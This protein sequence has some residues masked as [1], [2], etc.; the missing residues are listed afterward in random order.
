MNG[1]PVKS[2]RKTGADVLEKHL[3]EKSGRKSNNKDV[4]QGF[5]RRSGCSQSPI[6][7]E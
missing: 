7:L 5:N 2:K 1:A 4:L 3:N 6:V